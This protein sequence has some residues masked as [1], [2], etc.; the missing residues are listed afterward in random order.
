M[1]SLVPTFSYTPNAT[2]ASNAYIAAQNKFSDSLMDPIELLSKLNNEAIA[3]KEREEEKA[4]RAEDR[5]W[6]LEDRARAAKERQA[7]DAYYGE[8]ARGV[9]TKGGIYGDALATESNKYDL[10][11]DE[12]LK[13]TLYKNDAEQ[14]RAAGETVLADK[15]AWQTKVSDNVDSFMQSG[16]GDESR[17]EMYDRIN[18]ILAGKGL[19]IPKEAILS[20]DQARLAEKTAEEN[21][22]KRLKEAKAE[23]L[24]NDQA[25]AWKLVN[26]LGNTRTEIDEYGNEVQVVGSRAGTSGSKDNSFNKSID[27][28]LTDVLKAIE[29]KTKGTE[30]TT[31]AVTSEQ[32]IK[33][34]NTLVGEEG[35][36]ADVA[37]NIVSMGIGSTQPGW[38]ELWLGDPK[39][40]L[41]K[42]QL[43]FILPAA[44][45]AMA[46]KKNTA[47]TTGSGVSTKAA[48]AAKLYQNL[49]EESLLSLKSILSEQAKLARGAEG[50]RADSVNAWLQDRGLLDKSKVEESAEQALGATGKPLEAKV[51]KN[52]KSIAGI[53]DS[54]VTSE[55]VTNESYKDGKGYSIAMGYNL[56]YNKDDITKD[57]KDANISPEKAFIAKTRPQDLVLDD[58][59]A[60]RLSQVAYYKYADSLDKALGGTLDKLSPQMQATALQMHYR[61]DLFKDADYAKELRKY[62]KADDYDG[63]V[64]YVSENAATLP[65]PVVRRLENDLGA[66]VTSNL[67]G[68]MSNEDKIAYLEK[69]LSGKSKS[70]KELF[71]GSDV[72]DAYASKK[73]EQDKELSSSAYA[74]TFGPKT[75]VGKYAKVWEE[76]DSKKGS[77]LS[78]NISNLATAM[79]KDGIST[80]EEVATLYNSMPEGPDKDAVGEVLN[81]KGMQNSQDW[82][83]AKAREEYLEAGLTALSAIPGGGKFAK[84]AIVYSLKNTIRDKVV[85]NPLLSLPNFSTGNSAWVNK[86]A[87]IAT[88]KL[89]GVNLS[90]ALEKSAPDS[91]LINSLNSA[92]AVKQELA[93]TV[94]SNVANLN[95][96]RLT[97]E[98]DKFKNETDARMLWK[99]AIE[100]QRNGQITKEHLMQIMRDINDKSLI[101]IRELMEDLPK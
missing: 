52:I 11:P 74:R 53:P 31:K 51:N 35:I 38:K 81:Y 2:A 78:K 54:M 71:G 26:A 30:N 23:I 12:I 56:H 55:G 101:N 25:N 39:A 99:G 17:V 27:D 95:Y 43:S 29:E 94:P 6:K 80:F 4:I 57:F 88:D 62:V 10:T 34:Y 47:S 61:G 96:F 89:N 32:A 100:A 21:E 45:E 48:E 9:Q 83:D 76:S 18:S 5:A 77:S 40:K 65:A 59:E 60:Q 41:S 97:K 86:N 84:D 82:R 24:K 28:G 63:L 87:V 79:K 67:R 66:P 20:A 22:A 64:K 36:S 37:S 68:T 73:K 16:V 1:G 72:I 50:R 70:V 3:A 49:E 92:N 90:R 93:N 42:D 75:E 91:A 85:K 33:L 7:E 44:K 19:P 69:A 13:A 46:L 98:L 8:L 58:G 15:L 14:A